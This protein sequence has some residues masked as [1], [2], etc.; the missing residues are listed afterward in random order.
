MTTCCRVPDFSRSVMAF[1]VQ[2]CHG[3]RQQRGADK[4]IVGNMV[5]LDVF[6][7]P[8]DVPVTMLM[9]YIF[10]IL[11][12]GNTHLDSDLFHYITKHMNDTRGLKTGITFVYK[13]S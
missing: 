5:R 1:S 7:I 8:I 4:D 13:R 2:I 3:F 10:K 11:K 6:V 12:L 9:F